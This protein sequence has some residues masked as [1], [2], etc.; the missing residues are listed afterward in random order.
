MCKLVEWVS[1][2]AHIN[3][4]VEWEKEQI[5]P[6][7]NRLEASCVI[8]QSTQSPMLSLNLSIERSL[9]FPNFKLNVVDLFVPMCVN[10]SD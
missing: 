9:P 4:W 1:V 10:V 2:P 6:I 5:R 3:V 8:T 7:V